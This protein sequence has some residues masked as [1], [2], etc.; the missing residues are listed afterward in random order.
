MAAEVGWRDPEMYREALSRYR[1]NVMARITPYVSVV[2]ESSLE[3]LIT[4]VD[5]CVAQETVVEF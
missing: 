2:A 5:S 3:G 4:P 1:Q